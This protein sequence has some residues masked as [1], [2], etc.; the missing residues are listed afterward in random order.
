MTRKTA[1]ACCASAGLPSGRRRT[2]RCNKSS[3]AA[4]GSRPPPWCA[5]PAP[6]SELQDLGLQGASTRTLL[7]LVQPSTWPT[8]PLMTP[9]ARRIHSALCRPVF[10]LRTLHAVQGQEAVLRSPQGG[11]TLEPD[12][13]GI[14]AAPRLDRQAIQPRSHLETTL[15]TLQGQEAVLGS[16]QGGLTLESGAWGEHSDTSSDGEESGLQ[17]FI[18]NLAA[19]RSSSGVRALVHSLQQICCRLNLHD[20]Q[21]GLQDVIAN[22]AA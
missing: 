3:A 16:P 18:A 6:V 19:Q 12:C 2:A 9:M 15:Y 5:R 20:E 17:D 14:L 11:S 1:E 4:T 7:T 8:G 22:L 21:S 10:A 13:S